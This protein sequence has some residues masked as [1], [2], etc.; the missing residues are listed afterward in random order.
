[1]S[2]SD[3]LTLFSCRTLDGPFWSSFPSPILLGAGCFA[4][5][6]STTIAVVFPMTHLDQ[7]P[8]EGLG[9]APPYLL[10]LYVWIY[11]IVFWFIQDAVKVLAVRTMTKYN[12]LGENLL[13]QLPPSRSPPLFL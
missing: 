5:T 12:I 9:R 6:L 11:C 3:F 2:I 7:I 13:C 4:L 8:V 10:A 1:V